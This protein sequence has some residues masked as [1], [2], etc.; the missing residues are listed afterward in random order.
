MSVPMKRI[1]VVVDLPVT[2]P[3]L[4]FEKYVE[5][6]AAAVLGG[7][8]ARY[9][10][11]LYGPWG[12]GKSSILQALECRLA[13]SDDPPL[14]VKF[15]A[16][17]HERIDNVMLPFLWTIQEAVKAVEELP[18]SRKLSKAN[19]KKA[20]LALGNLIRGMEFGALGL[21]TVKMPDQAGLSDED[22]V[23]ASN[24]TEKY[25]ESLKQLQVLGESISGRIV[26]LIDDLDRCSPDRVVELIEAIRLLMDVDGFVFVLAIDYEV[27]LDAIRH[28]YQHADAEKFI[29]KIVQ[30]PFWIPSLQIDDENLLDSLIPRWDELRD[31]W[32]ADV[33]AGDLQEIFKLA[34]RGNPRQIK[35]LMNSY[36]VARHVVG[37]QEEGNNLI[38]AASI[39]MQLR[40]PRQFRELERRLNATMNSGKS[41]E[42]VENTNSYIGL[43][44]MI[45]NDDDLNQSFERGEN[46]DEIQEKNELGQ[47]VKRFF[48]H[49]LKVG[50]LL[51]VMRIAANVSRG[52]S[53]E[54]LSARIQQSVKAGQ[55]FETELIHKI[56]RLA[57]G[58][59]HN[60]ETQSRAWKDSDGGLVIQ[61]QSVNHKSSEALLEFGLGYSIPDDYLHASNI[62]FVNAEQLEDFI[63]ELKD[64]F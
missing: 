35:R 33:K 26:V 54:D 64:A 62:A 53:P 29:E 5:A 8:P 23:S 40:W 22:Q 2:T 37:E 38:L 48:G 50:G 24:S 56:N 43:V 12:T 21:F 10:I 31:D 11:G 45:V 59:G 27:L 36:L 57:T 1:P 20:A 58:A 15:D 47:Y 13:S 44:D 46:A 17:R 4:G 16:W 41:E 25:M 61:V 3:R 55:T 52:T 63:N 28:K 32:F 51:A 30:V 42:L 34:L 7:S 6:L 14:V 9:T 39:A 19:A 49:S 60:F 18:V